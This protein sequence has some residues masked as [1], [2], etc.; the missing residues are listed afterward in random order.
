MAP[1]GADIYRAETNE[2]PMSAAINQHVHEHKATSHIPIFL[3][4]NT[5]FDLWLRSSLPSCS[6]D[7]SPMRKMGATQPQAASG[8]LSLNWLNDGEN[9]ME[10]EVC[11]EYMRHCRK[12]I[13]PR[14]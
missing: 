9:M 1:L 10:G 5:F 3:A 4:P 14:T 8:S 6:A 11:T 12:F 2:D 7:L 13:G